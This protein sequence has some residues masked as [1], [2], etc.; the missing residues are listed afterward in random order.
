MLWID[1]DIDC[2]VLEGSGVGEVDD[3]TE[4]GLLKATCVSESSGVSK[5]F[6]SK[7]SEVS[8]FTSVISESI[9]EVELMLEESIWKTSIMAPE[10]NFLFWLF[11][12]FLF[13]S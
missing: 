7:L 8:N 4:F 6:K 11:D 9:S 5:K 10:V 3:S 13:N 12:L 1:D 2:G